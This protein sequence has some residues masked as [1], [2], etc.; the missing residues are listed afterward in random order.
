MEGPFLT[1]PAQHVCEVTWKQHLWMYFSIPCFSAEAASQST[2]NAS[3]GHYVLDIFC[4]C[5]QTKVIVHWFAYIV[6]VK[7]VT[8]HD[9]V[10]EWRCRLH[11]SATSIAALGKQGFLFLLFCPRWSETAMQDETT[12]SLFSIKKTFP[13]IEETHAVKVTI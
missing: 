1:L 2:S 6:Y 7:F 10:K 9:I 4:L 12:E 11:F 3:W 13:W 5:L 8:S